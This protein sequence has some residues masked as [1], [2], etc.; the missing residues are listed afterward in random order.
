MLHLAKFDDCR[1]Q[2]SG[3]AH[4]DVFLIILRKTGGNAKVDAN[5]LGVSSMGRAYADSAGSKLTLTSFR[6]P[7][8]R[9][10]RYGRA[11]EFAR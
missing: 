10:K 4:C 11:A 9:Q 3:V 2:C 7:L 1:V 8:A 6:I 5:V